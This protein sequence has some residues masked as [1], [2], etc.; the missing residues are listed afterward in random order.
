MNIM[1][2]NNLPHSSALIVHVCLR[3]LFAHAGGNEL[4]AQLAIHGLAATRHAAS[5][6]QRNPVRAK[7]RSRQR[8]F[9]Q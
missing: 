6:P 8:I 5:G 9:A 1:I 3:S 7:P 4:G 2:Y